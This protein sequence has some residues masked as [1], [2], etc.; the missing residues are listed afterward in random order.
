MKVSVDEEKIKHLL[1]HAV[2][3]VFV[4]ESLEKKL[5]SGKQLRVKLGFDPTSP[6]LHIGRA[7]VLWKLREFQDLGHKVVFIVGDFTALVGDP[8]D[9]LEKRPM[10]T[11]KKVKDNLK[12]YRAQVGKVLD[13]RKAEFHFNSKWLRKLNFNDVAELAE[14]FSLQ[15]MSHRRNFADR[16]EKGEEISLREFLYP[17]MQ[18]YD[19]VAVKADVELGGFDQ[20][21]NLKAGRTIQKHYGQ[22][23]QDIMNCQMLEGTDGRKMSSS[24]GNVINLLDEPNDMYGKVMAVRDDLILKY[25]TLCTRLSDEEINSI[26]ESIDSGE[27]PR[28][29][30]MRLGREIVSLY[31]GAK[32]AKEAE[33][34]F[35]KTFQKGGV[36]EDAVS[37]AVNKGELLVEVLLK[38][39]IISSKNEWKRLVLESAVLNMDTEE[40]ITDPYFKISNPVT[41]RVGKRRFIKIGIK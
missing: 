9:K 3:E 5:R 40:K 27:N 1:S 7:I 36:S 4:K 22:E 39:K 26:K 35:I 18:G 23:E 15:Q 25:F 8:S 32:K 28:D 12:N 41:L 34:D 38:E 20:L 14:C 31:H 2:E 21:F 24:W 30:K 11:A 6:F 17:L 29:A 10:L 13:L 16:I 19:S 33:D 37:V